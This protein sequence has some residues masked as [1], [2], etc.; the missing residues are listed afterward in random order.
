MNEITLTGNI[1]KY[2][3]LSHSITGTAVLSFSIGIN[4]RRFDKAQDRWIPRPTVWQDVVVFGEHAENVYD[5]VTTGDRVVV[6]G[7]LADNSYTKESDNPAQQ[8]QAIRRTQLEAQ[9]IGPDLN[10]ARAK[11]TKMTREH[12]GQTAPAA[13]G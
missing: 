12:N 10:Y 7:K 11:V 1:G 2:V 6:V 3:R 9:I 8:D 5:S 4:E 13:T